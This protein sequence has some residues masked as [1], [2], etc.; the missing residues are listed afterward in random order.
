MIRIHAPASSANLGP[1]FDCL[2]LALDIY[3]IFEVQEA[4]ETKLRGVEERFCNDDN[5]FLQ[6]YRKGCRL[7]GREPHIHVHF[8]CDIP[9]SRGMGS[10]AA[11][12]TAGLCAASAV[13]E[14][15]LDRD[16]IFQLASEAEGHPDNIAP[17]LFGGLTASAG[18]A[19]GGFV[20]RR[21]GLAEDWKYTLLIPD[22]EV[23]TQQA[24][25]ILP[26]SYPRRTACANTA[27]AIL[28]VEALR[29]GD[30]TL[31]KQ[32]ARDAVHEPFR[33]TLISG[34]DTLKAL[35]EEDSGGV[36]LISGSG[37]ACLLISKQHLS[38]SARKSV[39]LLPGNWQI[40]ETGPALDGTKIR[41]EDL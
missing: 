29:S 21:L 2:G 20:C 40:R 41:V 9:V 24:R 19:E 34:Y 22:F 7:G 16:V 32:C 15:P 14:K 18:L 6:A 39:S 17:C 13:Q 10:S 3:N 12:I 1:G 26:D 28:S 23:S 4:S 38:D 5:L 8:S 25:A 37:S 30:E 27:N 33:S 35:T 36:M 11:L 31:L